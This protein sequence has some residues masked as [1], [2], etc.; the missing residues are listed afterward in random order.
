MFC[1]AIRFLSERFFCYTDNC[2]GTA[3]PKGVIIYEGS[4]FYRDLLPLHQRRRDAYQDVE[5]EPEHAGHEVLIVTTSPKAVCHY[6]KDGVFVLPRHPPQTHLRVWIRPTLSTSS[7]CASFRILTRT[8]FISTPSSW[9]SL[10]SLPR[11]A[12]SP[13]RLHTATDDATITCSMRRAGTVPEHGQAGRSCLFPQRP[14]RLLR[15]SA[16]S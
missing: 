7:A 13:C 10:R 1:T 12:E 14:T 6:V 16:V 2:M 8:S 9:V 3:H 5:G 15:S 11:A 4:Y